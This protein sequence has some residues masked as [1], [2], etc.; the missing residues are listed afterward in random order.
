M[1][2]GGQTGLSGTWHMTLAYP[3]AV[4]NLWWVWSS[5][6]ATSR[7]WVDCLELGR[8]FNFDRMPC[9]T[10]Q[11]ETSRSSAEGETLLA[12]STH[13][14]TDSELAAKFRLENFRSTTV[15]SGF[16]IQCLASV[17]RLDEH[18]SGHRFPA[19]KASACSYHV[20]D[21]RRKKWPTIKRAMLKN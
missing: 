13:E 12:D 6:E 10:L 14:A 2:L 20:P 4:C 17:S 3:T 5:T 7:A 18:R 9:A 8:T 15:W 11:D 1:A 19:M 16:H 21:I